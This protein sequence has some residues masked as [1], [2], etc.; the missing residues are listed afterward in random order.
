ME[1]TEE[2][3]G[4]RERQA[5]GSEFPKEAIPGVDREALLGR[6]DAIKEL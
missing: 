1:V 3:A 2:T 6:R 4:A 5:H